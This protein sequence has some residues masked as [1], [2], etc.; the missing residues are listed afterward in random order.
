MSI[1]ISSLDSKVMDA[2]SE[3]LG[4]SVLTL[5]DN[6]GKA[7]ADLLRE[8]FHGQRFIIF[9]GHGNNGGDG[10]AT[11]IHLAEEDVSVCIIG[12]P[13]KVRPG[14]ASTYLS[15]LGCPVVQFDPNN[16][17]YDVLV[18]AV[19]GTGTKGKLRPEIETYIDYTRKFQGP[20]VSID[21]P[22][23]I[24]SPKSVI[25]D[26][27]ITM[28]DVKEGMDEKNSGEIVVADIGI[29]EKA[30]THT[31]PGDLYRYP[32]P[33]KDSHKGANGS[34][35]VIGGGP[36]YGA[37]AMAAMAAM[38]T[39]VDLV[40]I[41]TPESSYHEV[42]AQSPVLMVRKLRGS[43]L[44]HDHVKE[45]LK[46]SEVCDAVL[47]GPGLGR[48]EH[49]FEAVK[50]FVSLCRKPLVIDAD[51][52]NA[53]GTDFNAK[54]PQTVLT[55]HS[56]EYLRIGGSSKDPEDVRKT[57][58][59]LG[60]TIVLKGRYDIISNG[61]SVKINGTG[62]PGMTTGGTGDVLAGIIGG[63]LAKGMDAYEA[64][65]LGAYISG[66]A[67]ELAF[68]KFSYGMIATDVIDRIPKALKNGFDRL[69]L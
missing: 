55:P 44:C 10:F 26:I 29:P 2:N 19:L 63:L 12:D 27:T 31:G 32:I 16:R 36:Y 20:I 53:L 46:M 28:H 34:L 13:S 57:S 15:E 17:D 5:M 45:L 61:D 40:T 39:G 33:T 7:V 52:L 14:A 23:G 58:S 41:A 35:L 30:Y 51:G 37:P 59:R 21:V 50:E 22:T 43:T 66:K 1:M 4:T 8:R 62:T 67:G 68:N 47:I 25:P 18:D 48:D 64:G 42:A 69:G 54:G 38:R 65:Y 6:A 49:T 9:C 24:G 56:G 11:A 3:A 60:C